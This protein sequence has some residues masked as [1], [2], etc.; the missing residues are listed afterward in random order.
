MHEDYYHDAADDHRASYEHHPVDDIEPEGE[1]NIEDL[2]PAQKRA[3]LRVTGQAFGEVLRW[4]TE[5]VPV[6]GYRLPNL[7]VDP[8]ALKRG[9]IAIRAVVV[10]YVLNPSAFGADVNATKLSRKL[11]LTKQQFSWHVQQFR[12]R[13]EFRSKVMRKDAERQAMSDAMRQSW[14]RRAAK[15]RSEGAMARRCGKE[16]NDCPYRPGSRRAQLWLD[17]WTVN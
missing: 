16:K 4:V 10:Q 9:T 17:G 12:K 5:E 1:I 2:S 15:L 7:K 11:G 6:T 3:I 14:A 8:K 13:F